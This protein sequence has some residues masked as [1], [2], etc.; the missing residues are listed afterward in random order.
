[1]SRTA[2]KEQDIARIDAFFWI[3][4][5]E[6]VCHQRLIRCDTREIGNDP[7]SNNTR[8]DNNGRIKEESVSVRKRDVQNYKKR[9]AKYSQLI[10]RNGDK[11]RCEFLWFK[12][13]FLSILQGMIICHDIINKTKNNSAG[14]H[15]I[16]DYY[17]FLRERM[18]E[19]K[20]RN[21]HN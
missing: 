6:E 13:G 15:F 14:C 2:D 16:F 9:H 17:S 1:M 10:H 4:I 21:E 5:S 18:A 7:K 11:K 3:K 20:L 12:S 8:P 19:T